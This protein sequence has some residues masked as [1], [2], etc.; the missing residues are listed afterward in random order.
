MLR[1]FDF[2]LSED[3]LKSMLGIPEEAKLTIDPN[4]ANPN[5]YDITITIDNDLLPIAYHLEKNQ[6]IMKI[7]NIVRR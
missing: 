1:T 2:P 4:K 3:F 7:K 5:L 6:G